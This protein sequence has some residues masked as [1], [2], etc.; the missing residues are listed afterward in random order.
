VADVAGRV[1]VRKYGCGALLDRAADG[2]VVYAAGPALLI[3]GEMARVVDRGNQKFL[4]TG[5]VEL[6]A[7]ADHL[8]ALHQFM[9]ELR[10]AAGTTVLYNE[11][12][13]TVSNKYDYDRLQ[14][15]DSV[16]AMAGT[17]AGH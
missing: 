8:H 2:G 4:V 7:S 16:R 13:G 15:R 1:L 3:G 17:T 11:A 9:E 5:R 6:P 14:G 12:L 10:W